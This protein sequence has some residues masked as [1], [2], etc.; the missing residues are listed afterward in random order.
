MN[1]IDFSYSKLSICH[2]DSYVNVRGDAAKAIAFGLA[3]LIVIRGITA[4]LEKAN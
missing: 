2:N 3:A 1:S 4:V